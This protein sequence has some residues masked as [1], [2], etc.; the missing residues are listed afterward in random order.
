MRVSGLMCVWNCVEF[1]EQAILGI[2]DKVDELVVVDGSWNLDNK[3]GSTDG[4][5]EK[6]K[7]LAK[8]FDKKI[9]FLQY[10]PTH[11]EEY[12]HYYND[13]HKEHV[14]GHFNKHKNPFY[15]PGRLSQQQLGRDFGL[16]FIRSRYCDDPDGHWLLIVDSDEFYPEWQFVNGKTFHDIIEESVA[17]ATKVAFHEPTLLAIEAMNFYFDSRHFA[18]E[19]FNRIFRLRRDSWFVDSNTITGCMDYRYNIPKIQC[20]FFHY[21]Y[22]GSAFRMESKLDRW[23]DSIVKPWIERVYN[24]P[25]FYQKMRNNGGGIHLLGSVHPGYRRYMLMEYGGE[26]PAL[27]S[28]ALGKIVNENT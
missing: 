16:N 17:D 22:I 23:D 25:N 19:R 27:A 9:F 28:L 15:K 20:M 5:E 18:N 3:K 10:T 26:H 7:K 12:Q 6:I 4:T 13:E 1:V 11:P 14:L 21:S 8:Q 2:I 24:E